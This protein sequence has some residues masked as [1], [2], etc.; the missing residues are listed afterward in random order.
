MHG[1]SISSSVSPPPWYIHA[2]YS[3]IPGPN[4]TEANIL[5][6]ESVLAKKPP[7]DHAASTEP[8][9]VAWIA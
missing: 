3:G 6:A 1:S 2:M 4:G 7:F 5:N 8:W 9:E